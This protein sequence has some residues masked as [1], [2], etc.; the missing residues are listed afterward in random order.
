MGEVIPF[1]PHRVTLAHLTGEVNE[2]GLDPL[3]GYELLCRRL[4]HAGLWFNTYLSSSITSG[5]HARDDSLDIVQVIQRNTDMAL[6]LAD[7]LYRSSQ[8]AP[9]ASI[10]AVMLGK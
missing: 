4:G 9:E 3:E 7:E 10:E 2:T 5:G 1:R 6:D 8:L